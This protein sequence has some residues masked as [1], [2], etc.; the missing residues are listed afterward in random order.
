MRVQT[1]APAA[2]AGLSIRCRLPRFLPLAEQPTV[3][4]SCLARGGQPKAFVEQA[5]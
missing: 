5:P 2:T 4:G 1:L 3:E